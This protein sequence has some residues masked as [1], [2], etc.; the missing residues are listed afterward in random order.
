MPFLQRA[1][2][3]TFNHRK[4]D[5][6]DYA[7][8]LPIVSL[9]LEGRWDP[10]AHFDDNGEVMIDPLAT[11][12]STQY[13]S[14]VDIINAQKI[15]T[16]HHSETYTIFQPDGEQEEVFH[17]TSEGTDKQFYGRAF[18]LDIPQHWRRYKDAPR[19]HFL[20]QC[21]VDEFWG[22]LTYSGTTGIPTRQPEE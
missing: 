20:R 13:K 17:D 12:V 18:H 1:G 7:R 19:N 16:W 10:H 4:P 2:L 11:F 5:E 21:H 22:T 15:S 8:G 9:T 6:M 3:M 14:D